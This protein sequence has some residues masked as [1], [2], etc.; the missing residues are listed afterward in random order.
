MG[1]ISLAVGDDTCRSVELHVIGTAALLAALG[2]FAEEVVAHSR[3]GD[4]FYTFPDIQLMISFYRRFGTG[5]DGRLEPGRGE[6]LARWLGRD[7]NSL[8]VAMNRMR[9]RGVLPPLRTMSGPGPEQIA[10]D[11]TLTRCVFQTGRSSASSSPSN[12]GGDRSLHRRA[13]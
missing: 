12:G 11:L 13:A 10:E 5:T 4:R 8:A 2:G 3:V 1:D 7:T 6:E 9:R